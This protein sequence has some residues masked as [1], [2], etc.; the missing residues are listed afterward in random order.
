M[1]RVLPEPARATSAPSCCA[2]S[3]TRAAT[4]SSTAGSRREA[5]DAFVAEHRDEYMRRVDDTAFMHQQEL[6]F[7][8]FESVWD[9]G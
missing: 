8:T 2:T 9:A 3:S 7:G 6:H 4:W 1:G 5:Y